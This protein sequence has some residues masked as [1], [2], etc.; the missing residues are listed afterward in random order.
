M[1]TLEVVDRPVANLS[2]RGG[3]W[4]P[5]VVTGQAGR[6]LRGTGRAVALVALAT[7]TILAASVLV[8]G[9]DGG[10]FPGAVGVRP[11][12][13]PAAPTSPAAPS[14]LTAPAGSAA[15]LSPTDLAAW[16]ELAAESIDTA[17]LA[18]GSVTLPYGA[19]VLA[20]RIFD[21]GPAPAYA[22]YEAGGGGFNN[23]FYAA[24][25]IKLLAAV[26]ALSYV[27]SFGFTGE[28]TI[29]G[30][31]TLHEI[32]D[33]AIRD[34]SNSD[35]SWLVRI[36]GTEW[37]NREF[38]PREGFYASAIQEA[39]GGE[40][41]QVAY[42]PAMA[43]AEGDRALDVE[44]RYGY[45]DYGC[46]GANCTDL[47]DLADA[48]RRVVLD[49]E[50]PASER[51]PIAPSDVAGLDDALLGAPSWLEPG[52]HEALG[53]EALIFSKPGWVGGLD[54]VDAALVVDPPTGRRYLI[55]LSVPDYGDECGVLGT[56]AYDIITVLA[57][58]DNGPALRT[59]GAVVPIVGGK[60]VV[61]RT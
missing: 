17:T 39:Y 11:A 43:L 50:I 23:Q 59:D 3:A 34:S 40:G 4:H 42:S 51:F 26:G 24:S 54:C 35:Y 56:M 32:Y 5:L 53:P 28:A 21:G 18:D 37:L 38:L 41:E 57:A 1:S 6:R 30:G 46:G 49:G 15:A 25:S 13:V 27:K 48:V 19:N 44:E 47:F 20:A 10:V 52:V 14:N 29:D 22:F 55:A 45:D 61:A 58:H 2:C 31:Y 60:Q 7:V 36:A 16:R 33:A 9:D 8:G 12:D